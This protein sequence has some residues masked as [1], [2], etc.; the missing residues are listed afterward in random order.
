M[1]SLYVRFG[2]LADVGESFPNV[3]SIPKSGHPELRTQCPLSLVGGGIAAFSR[4]S[5][6][7]FKTLQ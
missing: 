2:S 6:A 3:R 7:N 5:K 1:K 4:S